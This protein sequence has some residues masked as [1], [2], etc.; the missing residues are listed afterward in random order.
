MMWFGE[1]V[2]LLCCQDVEDSA[3]PGILCTSFS[4]AITG[5]RFLL[6]TRML[7][8]TCL[9]WHFTLTPIF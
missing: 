7:L 6:Q 5:K 2:G 4:V 9:L 1:F 8:H 3:R